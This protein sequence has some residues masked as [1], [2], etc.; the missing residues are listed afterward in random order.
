MDPNQP[1]GLTKSESRPLLNPALFAFQAALALLIFAFGFRL[2]AAESVPTLSDLVVSNPEG[3]RIRPFQ[4]ASNRF[5]VFIFIRND[6]PISNHYSPAARALEK[7]FA[8]RG[9]A[10]WLVHPG[11]DETA[12]SIRK[13]AAEYGLTLPILLDPDHQLVKLAQAT[14]TPEAA[15]FDRNARLVYHGRID[16][17]Y[18]DFGRM[19]PEARDKTLEK[20][21]ELL[22]AGKPLPS[23][24]AKAIGCYIE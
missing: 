23:S 15:V 18:V 4:T 19:R 5:V 6:C 21:L 3:E 1:T 13:H 8:A 16:D 9:I 7:R 12:A 24:A 10:F 11:R 14:V 22:L 2:A 20:N 17:Q